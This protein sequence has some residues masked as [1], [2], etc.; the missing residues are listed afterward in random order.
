MKSYRIDEQKALSDAAIM[1]AIRDAAKGK[2]KKKS[3]RR[4]LENP[5]SYILQIREMIQTGNIHLHYESNLLITDKGSGKERQITVPRFWPDQVLHH[6]LIDAI[7]PG[8]ER[9]MTDAVCASIPGRGVHYGKRKVEKWLRNDEKHTRVIAKLDIRHFYQSI[10]HNRLKAWLHKKI[11][12]SCIRDALDVV[13]DASDEGLPLGCY[14][15][16]WLANFYLEPLDHLIEEMNGVNHYLRYMDDMV[17]FG[18]SKKKMH[19]AVRKV[20]EYLRDPLGLELKNNWQVFRF[21]YVDKNGNTHGRPL[22]FMGYK[23]RRNN[24]I[25]RRR[26]AF[27]ISRLAKAIGK[28]K[29]VS[30]HQ[31]RAMLSY[32]GYIKSA[33]MYDF[34]LHYVRPYVDEKVLKHIVSASDRDTEKRR[35]NYGT[36][37]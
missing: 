9:G 22:D 28:S 2:H 19:K 10:D 1:D 5:D 12:P 24:T 31:A 17:L 16:Q 33:D 25:L 32:F 34:Y 18:S 7:R 3:V 21:E 11:R 26:I 37:V 8:I 30:L 13:I 20:K 6:I 27:S 14:T 15:S 36:C 35:E 29:K 23:F 4:I